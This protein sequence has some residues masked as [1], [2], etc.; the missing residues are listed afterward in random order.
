MTVEQLDVTIRISAIALLVFLSLAMLRSGVRRW[1][2]PQ[3]LFLPMALCVSAFLLRNTP[4]PHLRPDGAVGLLVEATRP[5]SLLSIWWFCLACFEW[6]FRPCRTVIGISAAWIGLFAICKID[7]VVS[8]APGLCEVAMTLLCYAV[9][10]QLAYALL[11]RWRDDLVERRRTARLWVVVILVGQ[12]FVDLTFGV[13]NGFE[14][15]PIAFSLIQNATFL[16]FA[17]GLALHLV[18]ARTDSLVF[19]ANLAA[20]SLHLVAAD[21]PVERIGHQALKA[22]LARLIEQE[23]IYLR[24]DLTFQMFVDAAGSNAKLVRKTINRDMGF[25]HFRTFLSHYRIAEA[26]RRLTDPAHAQDKMIAIAHDCGFASVQSF[27]R[28]FREIEGCSPSEFRARYSATE[29][30][31][32]A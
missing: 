3:L 27:N 2:S 22:R 31:R 16:G 23:R 30:R 24:P 32:R 26:R 18:S 29:D 10:G 19:G 25:D 14:V 13:F 9:I 28:I 7:A 15:R 8:L 12:L 20:P 4:F 6:P 11:S 5:F 21:D 17:L 1:C